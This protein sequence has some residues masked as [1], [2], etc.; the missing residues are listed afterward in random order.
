M[1]KTSRRRGA[2]GR[3]GA[4]RPSA[5]LHSVSISDLQAEIARRQRSASG[6]VKKRERLAAKVAELDRQLATF[7]IEPG[8]APAAQRRAS[9]PARTTGTGPGRRGPRGPRAKNSQS[10]VEAL[11]KAMTGRTLGVSEAAK[12]V[13]DAGYNTKSSNFRTVVNQTLL[14]NKDRFKKVERGRYTAK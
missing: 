4:T 6:L 12:A 3:A 10:L 14:V 8:A 2:R 9:T 1:A 13:L 5:P 11:H 7:G